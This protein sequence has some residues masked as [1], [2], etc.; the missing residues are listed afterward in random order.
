MTITSSAATPAKRRAR[1]AATAACAWALLFAALSFFWAAGGRTGIQPLEVSGAD[2]VGL[3]IGANVVAGLLKIGAGVAALAL[4]RVGACHRLYRPLLAF[5]WLAGVG[6]CLYGGLGLISDIL[7]VT[8]VVND[9][10]TRHWFFWYLVVWDPWWLLGGALFVA[11]ARLVGR[12][13]G[14]GLRG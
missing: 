13:S 8:G 9:P 7:H 6:M 2:N 1:R 4:A 11:T 12:A 5:A 10:A 14:R 3:R